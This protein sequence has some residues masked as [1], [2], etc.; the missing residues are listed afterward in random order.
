MR[1]AALAFILMMS[2]IT[3]GQ[4][5]AS[6]P[7]TAPATLPA[8]TQ[9][10]AT[11]T[12]TTGAAADTQSLLAL[13]MPST[14]PA[15]TTSVASTLPTTNAVAVTTAPTSGP[16]RPSFATT[17]TTS[18][19]SYYRADRYRT[20]SRTPIPPAPT[21]KVIAAGLDLTPRPFSNA[22]YVLLH[23]SIFIRGRQA[24]IDP[25]TPG[26]GPVYPTIGPPTTDPTQ[27]TTTVASWSPENVMVFNGSSNANGQMV[28]F[29]E[30][31][32]LN[33]IARF[34][35]GDSVA[36]GKITGIT[37]DQLDYLVS[38]RV[39][40]VMLGQNL[41][42]VDMQV[43]TT[44]PVTGGTGPTTSG[45]GSPGGTDDVLERLRLRRLKELGGQ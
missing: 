45:S 24:V 20:Y 18:P 37:L 14:Q 33:S 9:L 40:H 19:P 22:Y 26:N 25:G 8:Q 29:I 13:T 32:S 38:G 5:P 10:A 35:V 31:T 30:N 36:T 41:F 6:D 1:R 3:A 27:P 4:V 34:Q 28:A 44:Q 17:S 7:A 23:R 15:T 43:L 42:G 39:T 11:T 16:A 2:G 12:P 21:P